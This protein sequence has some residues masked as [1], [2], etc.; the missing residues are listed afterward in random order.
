MRERVCEGLKWC[1]LTLDRERNQQTIDREGRISTDDSRL[2]AY[3]IPV[4]EGLM[5]AYE[6][7]RMGCY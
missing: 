5:I 7:M 6:A 3:V 4:K 2:H 1:G